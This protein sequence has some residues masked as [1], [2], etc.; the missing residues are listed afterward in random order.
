[1]QKSCNSIASPDRGLVFVHAYVLHVFACL[2][3]NQS[4]MHLRAF[5]GVQGGC[6]NEKQAYSEACLG[7][8]ATVPKVQ[9]YSY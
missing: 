4:V 6:N 2:S 5:K 9:F 3:A 1:M 8:D 7:F